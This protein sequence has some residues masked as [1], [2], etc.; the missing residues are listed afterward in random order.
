MIHNCR[1]CGQEFSAK[2]A[3]KRVYCSHSCFCKSK[4]MPEKFWSKVKK[5]S[6]CWE[7]IGYVAPHGYG[8]VGGGE[9]GKKLYAHR[10]SYELTNGAIPADMTL[11]HLCRNRSCVNPNHLEVV[12]RGENSRRGIEFKMRTSR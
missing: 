5:G 11:D 9:Y 4:S 7:W 10:V 3:A 1:M 6:G 8:K 12:T 2:P